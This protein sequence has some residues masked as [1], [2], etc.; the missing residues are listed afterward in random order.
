[1][2][3]PPSQCKLDDTESLRLCSQSSI[4]VVGNLQENRK[5]IK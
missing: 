5:K 4:N 1:M 3:N 2:S